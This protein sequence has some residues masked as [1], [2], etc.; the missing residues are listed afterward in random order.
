MNEPKPPSDYSRQREHF[1]SQEMIKM[2]ISKPRDNI[3]RKNP[4]FIR[5]TMDDDMYFPPEPPSKKHQAFLTMAKS[6]ML[7][8]DS[9]RKDFLQKAATQ[10]VKDVL[11][12]EFGKH[13]MKDK[14]FSHMQEAI[15]NK[16]LENPDYRH[17]LQKLLGLMEDSK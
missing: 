2:D 1:L 9:K 13:F 10:M 7:K 17:I 16:L 6:Q 15:T 5:L 8:M 12:Q 3:S 11:G 4:S 14:G